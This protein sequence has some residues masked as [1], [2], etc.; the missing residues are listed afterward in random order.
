MKVFITGA[1]G[2]LGKR[3]VKSL[4]SKNIS[5]IALSRSSQNE[6][7]LKNLGAESKQ[8]DLFNAN[9]M[10]KATKGCDAILHLATHIPQKTMPKSK[11]WE[12]NDRIRIDGTKHFSGGGSEKQN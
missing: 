5:V 3:V 10:I 1:T 2:V 4:I 12:L 8:A 6:E 11:D 7:L 9:E